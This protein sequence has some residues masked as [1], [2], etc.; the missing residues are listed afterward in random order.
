MT[1][2]IQTRAML[3]NLSISSWTASK[4]DNTASR[5]TKTSAGATEKAG[6]FNKRLV[7]PASLLPIG[8]AEGRLRAYHYSAT[9]AWGDNGDR[10][11]PG[12]SF[13]SY[14][15]KMRELEAEFDAAVRT[16]IAAYPQLVQDARKMLGTMYQPSDY[17][18]ANNI[19]DRF[20][21]KKV[22]TPVPDVADFRVDIG[23]E[24]L[25]E[26]RK[27]LTEA[28]NDRMKG[29]ARECWMRMD[30]VVGKMCERL[31]D[32]KAIFKDSLIENVEVLVGL[33]PAL[34]IT[35]DVELTR[36]TNRMQSELVRSK[37]SVLRWNKARRQEVYEA[38]ESIRKEIAPWVTT[39]P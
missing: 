5:V 16:F 30:D 25:A 23:D 24:A 31:G 11:L 9:L 15:N 21:V 22:F 35:Q 2:F 20:A 19:R 14:T 29:A 27:G 37:A 18:D 28:I 33:L 6:W 8:T 36:V 13:F 38:A 34:N 32:P 1:R 17:P 3:V 12:E 4:K 10:I 26:I 7:D 39:T